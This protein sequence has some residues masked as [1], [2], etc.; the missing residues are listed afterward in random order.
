M[1]AVQIRR[2]GGAEVLEYV[3]TPT[4][5]PG[6]G[7]VL[8][9]AHAI[10]VNMPDVMVRAGSYPTPPPMPAILGLEMSGVVAEVGPGVEGLKAG[11]AVYVS[12]RE[13][14]KRAGCYA[15][16]MVAPEAALYVVP[17]SLDLD[18]VA[19]LAGYQVAYLLLNA[20]TRGFTYDSV[21]VQAAAG[22]IGSA[23]VELAHAAG[24]QVVAL[25]SSDEK[26]ET[27]MECGAT[28]ALNYRAEDLTA[29]IAT[30]T[31]GRG[32][33]LILDPIGGPGLATLFDHLAPLGLVVMFGFL[34]G[35]PEN[36]GQPIFKHAFRS[37]A[38]R[39]FSM[40]T[41][42]L[43]P[44]VRRDATNDLLRLMAD[45]AIR[46]RI[47]GRLPLSEAAR[48]HIMLEQRQVKGR[49]LLKP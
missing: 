29:Q 9:K 25:V 33:D 17:E 34:E 21:L 3:D 14:D 38:V 4:P 39:L 47:H 16:Y 32:I 8:V 37:P 6:P 44:Q 30:A 20:A 27:A 31:S 11:Q 18:F 13:M 40:H 26:I 7:E 41:F 48:A 19:T 28:L 45:G 42:D 23:I 5:R 49:L 2:T 36:L 22:G 1:K 24:K 46:P 12:A 15:E 10:G 35:R 43:M